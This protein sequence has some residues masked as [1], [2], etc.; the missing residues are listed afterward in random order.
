PTPVPLEDAAA[1]PELAA[2]SAEAEALAR[3]AA[4]RALVL[5]EHVAL[6]DARGDSDTTRR[7]HDAA[8]AATVARTVRR[9]PQARD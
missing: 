8:S 4:H 5:R 1:C 2:P 3:E 9:R 7:L 6:A